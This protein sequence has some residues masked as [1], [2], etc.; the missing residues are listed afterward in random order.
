VPRGRRVSTPST[1]Q[2]IALLRAL[3]LAVAAH[4]VS[5]AQIERRLCGRI[6]DGQAAQAALRDGSPERD[7][8]ELR[9]LI[10]RK[11]A[12]EESGLARTDGRRD[13]AGGQRIGELLAG[14][15]PR[16]VMP[17]RRRAEVCFDALLEILEEKDPAGYAAGR[18]GTRE[19]WHELWLQADQGNIPTLSPAATTVA[20]YLDAATRQLAELDETSVLTPVEPPARLDN[21]AARDEPDVALR[22]QLRDLTD[23]LEQVRAEA[24]RDADD[25]DAALLR[26]ETAE[27]E[28]A[29][30]LAELERQRLTGVRLRKIATVLSAMLSA[31][32]LAFIAGGLALMFTDLLRG[33]STYVV[34]LVSPSQNLSPDRLATF[35]LQPALPAN[36]DWTLRVRLTITPTDQSAGCSYTAQVTFHVEADGT[37]L[38]SFTSPPGQ[39]TVSQE[40]RLGGK[41]SNTLR[42]IVT[43]LVTDPE[44]VLQLSPDGS[45]ATATT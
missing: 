22:A 39:L 28:K 37:P 31:L 25:R 29:D 32:V 6:A 8:D 44:C 11:T 20:G 19:H 17:S 7:H 27:R 2:F 15:F 34:G 38:P 33:S 21:G 36:R 16:G 1:L 43:Q 18:Y 35:D 12:T 40:V 30:L 14:K 10:A 9:R 5:H 26:A 24:R 23:E 45:Q 4:G 41:G 42:L 3:D 13:K